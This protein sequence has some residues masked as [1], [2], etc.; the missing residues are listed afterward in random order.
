MIVAIIVGGAV[1]I[2]ALLLFGPIG[3][4]L[5]LVGALFFGWFFS[6]SNMT[7]EQKK[8]HVDNVNEAFYD[9]FGAN[10]KK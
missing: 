3:L 5:A 10:K 9:M 2:G 6:A 7:E 4:V 1:L 8:E